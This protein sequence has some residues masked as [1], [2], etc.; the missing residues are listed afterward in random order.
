MAIGYVRVKRQI[1]VGAEPGIKYMARLFRN[2]DVDL[3]RICKDISE[4]SSLSEGDVLN[5]LKSFETVFYR[6]IS[7]GHAV[8]L[9]YLGHFIPK[10]KSKTVN[11]LSQVTPET[12][13][14]VSVRF[15]PSKAF[16]KDIKGAGVYEVNTN[17]TGLQNLELG[18]QIAEE[19]QPDK[20]E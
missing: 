1:M 8:K 17:I 7:N 18:D 11:T 5:C 3:K 9:P 15:Y 10:F 20:K 16:K 14:D 13:T 2:N 19:E 12:V 6:Y 4:L